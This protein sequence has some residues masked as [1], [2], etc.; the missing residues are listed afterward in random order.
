MTAARTPASPLEQDYAP[1]YGETIEAAYRLEKGRLRP[2]ASSSRRRGL[3]RASDTGHLPLLGRCV[4]A[5]LLD[6]LQPSAGAVDVHNAPTMRLH[7]AQL[8]RDPVEG[9]GHRREV[10]IG[11]LLDVLIQQHSARPFLA[12]RCHVARRVGYARSSERVKRKG[13]KALQKS[14]LVQ[15]NGLAVSIAFSSSRFRKNGISRFQVSSAMPK[16]S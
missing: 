11:E 2:M 14:F 16:M 6:Q 10:V 12:I 8:Q 9:R 15:R 4:S 5:Q 13:V 1:F 7:L 3:V